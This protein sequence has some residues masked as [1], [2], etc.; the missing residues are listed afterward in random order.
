MYYDS[1]DYYDKD[2]ELNAYGSTNLI[3]KKCVVTPPV[4]ED[5]EEE[6]EGEIIIVEPEEEEE[7]EE[8]TGGEVTRE[9]SF[10]DTSLYLV[11][12][13]ATVVILAGIFLAMIFRLFPRR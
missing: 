11:L 5:E 10:M 8:P 1:S 9:I 13:V 6:E 12:L 3:I 2:F 7:E 4:E